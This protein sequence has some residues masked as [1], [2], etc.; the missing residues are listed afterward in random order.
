MVIAG[1][2]SVGPQ[3][4][5]DV[6]T[7]GRCQGSRLGTFQNGYLPW[8]AGSCPGSSPHCILLAAGMGILLSQRGNCRADHCHS[9]GGTTTM[10]P[11]SGPASEGSAGPRAGEIGGSRAEGYGE[12]AKGWAGGSGRS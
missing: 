6:Q 5:N 10:M 2:N 7:T 1:P 9:C 11:H 8:V 3:S 4:Q 12:A